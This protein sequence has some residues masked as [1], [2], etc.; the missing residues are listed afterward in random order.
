MFTLAQQ[1]K[2]DDIETGHGT[3]NEKLDFGSVSWIRAH[4]RDNLICRLGNAKDKTCS[5]RIS[6]TEL[7]RLHLRQL[8]HKILQ[9]TIDLRQRAVEP[10][11]WAEDLRQYGESLLIHLYFPGFRAVATL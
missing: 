8:Q 5:Y 2:Q 10:S 7:Q 3:R 1:Q 6:L 4:H 11:K 9:H